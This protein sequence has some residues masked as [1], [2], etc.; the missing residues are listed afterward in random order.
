MMSPPFPSK[1][2]PRSRCLA[3]LLLPLLLGA[4]A[5]ALAAEQ[6]EQ[7]EEVDE[8]VQAAAQVAGKKD[9]LAVPLPITS[10]SLGTG[11]VVAGV[12]F[13]NPNQAPSPWISGAAAMKTSNGNWL[14]GG[15]HSMSLDSDRFRITGVAGT[16]KLVADY[17]GIGPAAGDRN[18]SVD[19]DEKFVALRVQGQMRVAP[20]FY[21]GVRMLYLSSETHE[22]DL[23]PE[24][25]DLAIPA[26][27]ADSQLMQVGPALSYDTRDDTLNPR[28]G[29]YA[30]AEW[31]WGT[32]LLGGD[33]GS[34]RLTAGVSAYL[35]Q[36]AKTVLALHAGLCAASEGTPFYNLCLFGQKNDLRGYKTGRYRD[37]ASWAVQA[38]V[39]RQLFGRFGM[40][41]FA[42]LGGIAPAL[43]DLDQ[44]NLLP[45][46]G[47]GLRY[48]PSRQTNI[49]LRLDVA[50][51]K[52]SKG[53]YL[54]I[55]E[56]F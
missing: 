29:L 31:M 43:G 32:K 19:L 47:V 24:Y 51:G 46:G 55:A 16:G 52:D 39:R 41:A 27:E 13:Y 45:A 10:P 33:F 56:A 7:M 38:E 14:I 26:D 53:I 8:Q 30:H 34:H 5:P 18:V 6:A 12:I 22:Q 48:R 23:P 4:S 42:G 3:R 54:G 36:D 11:L 25:P 37:R 2:A 1:A 49:N 21:A 28:R 20:G 17:Y 9:L 35:P 44:S 50:V 15:L 40:V